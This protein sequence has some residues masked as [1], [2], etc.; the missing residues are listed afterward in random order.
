MKNTSS[1]GSHR[2]A[3]F[4]LIELLMVVAVIGVLS[5]LALPAYNTYAN[6][7]AFSEAILATGN[8]QSAFVVQA[9]SGQITALADADAGTNGI[10]P[11]VVRTVASHGMTVQDGVITITWRD[12]GTDL[13]GIT[14]T[15]AAQGVLPPIQWVPGGTCF[16][17]GYC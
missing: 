16:N 13:D 9:F 5:Q 11:S 15:L 17:A 14:Y 6:R 1:I 2:Q 4:T 12:D 8:Y 10:P 3:G 7:A